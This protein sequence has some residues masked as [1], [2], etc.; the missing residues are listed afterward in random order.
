MRYF[1]EIVEQGSLSRA[2]ARLNVAQPALSIHLRNMEAELATPLLL[3]GRGGVV[4]TEAGQILLRA[5]RRIVN[6]QVS[7]MDEIRSLGQEPSGEVRLGLPGTIADILAIPLIEAARR[8]YPRVRITLSEA[9]SG[10][11]AE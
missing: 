4:P 2:A 7:A 8:R 1:I 6:E 9:M 3:R 10:F 11:V 5:A